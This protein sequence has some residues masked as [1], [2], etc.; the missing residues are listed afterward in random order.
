ML[1]FEMTPE[2]L[3]LG[4]GP[5]FLGFLPEMFSAHDPRPAKE[6]LE[7]NYNYGGGWYP[8]RGFTL[9]DD[10]TLTHPGDPSMKPLFIAQFR[11]ETIYLYEA[12]W[13]AIVQSDRSFEVSRMD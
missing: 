1:L 12:S 6:Q 11:D 5:G 3:R 4:Y 10:G 13:V 9:L 7:E 2:A 8:F